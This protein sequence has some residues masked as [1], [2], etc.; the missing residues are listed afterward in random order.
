MTTMEN[1]RCFPKLNWVKIFLQNTMDRDKPTA[2]AMLSNA[3]Q[4]TAPTPEMKQKVTEVYSKTKITRIV[5]NTGEMLRQNI[6]L[7]DKITFTVVFVSLPWKTHLYQQCKPVNIQGVIKMF[8]DWFFYSAVD[9]PRDTPVCRVVSQ[10]SLSPWDKVWSQC[11]S[12]PFV[13]FGWREPCNCALSL[14]VPCGM[15]KEQ[16]QR[17]CIKFCVKLG[18][19]G[20]ETF[21]ILRT[22][23]GEQCLSHARIF[24]WHKR[25]KEAQD[26]VDDNPQSGR[27]TTSKTDDSVVRVRELIRANRRLTIRE[28]S[29]LVCLMVL[30]RP[31]WCTIWTCD[32][33]LQN[34]FC[35]FSPLNR[36]NSTCLWQQTCC[37]K[38]SQ[39]KTLWGKSSRATR[40]G[41]TGM[42]RRRNVS[43]RS[44]S[45][46]IP[47][48]QRKRARCGQKS[49]PCSLFSLIWR[50][51]FIMSTF[52]KAKL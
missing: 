48:G 36:R 41:S 45:L 5:F 16:E 39:M 31:Y 13:S 4:F 23:F 33:L 15:L 38:Q 19:N 43:L 50:A 1:E 26:F 18:R 8:R 17:L 29:R 27:P 14:F 35:E 42:T 52:H 44:G 12:Q 7:C 11:A 30:V 34:L 6:I 10:N 2:W 37:R 46:L 9:T 21:E 24:E 32:V 40:C 28:L 20:V 22:A 25:F 49:K 51:L 47:R 3:K